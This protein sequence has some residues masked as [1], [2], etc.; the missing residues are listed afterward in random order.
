[1]ID[2]P[3]IFQDTPMCLMHQAV[4]NDEWRYVNQ[5]YEASPIR[6]LLFKTGVLESESW[7]GTD[8][9]SKQTWVWITTLLLGRT[10]TTLRLDFLTREVGLLPLKLLWGVPELWKC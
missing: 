4:K 2:L 1:M 3:A 6:P 8:L 7:K 5:M 10:V 9:S